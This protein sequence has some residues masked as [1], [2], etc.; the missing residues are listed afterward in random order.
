MDIKK[1]DGFELLTDGIRK[2]ELSSEKAVIAPV[3]TGKLLARNTVFNLVGQALP[4][5]VAV[6]TIPTIIRALGV[7]RFGVLTLAWMVVGY[8]SLLDL[9]L[10]RATTKFVAEFLSRGESDRCARLVWASV[11]ML[12]T[13][14]LLGAAAAAFIMPWLVNDI[15]NIP[16]ELKQESLK[17]F[18]LL[19]ISIPIVTTT[20]GMRGV[21]EA[22]QRFDLINYVKIPTY[23]AAFAAPL[24][25][26]PFS[27]NLFPIVLVLIASRLAGLLVYTWFCL[28]S[29]PALLRPRLP[30][31]NTIKRLLGYGGW[32]TVSHIIWP[33]MTYLD[34][35]I[36]GAMLTMAAVA[37]YAT[38]YELVA[39]LMII[40][41]SLTS[42]VF[43]AFSAYADRQPEKL[44]WLH[45][46]TIKYL[47][48]SLVPIVFVIIVMATPLFKIWI[49]NDFA[50]NSA[51]ILQ[52]LALAKLIN[53][54]SQVPSSAIQAMGR[55][56]ITA[57][58]HLIEL[59]I[60]LV[61][62]WIL[63]NSFGIVGAAIAWL[64]RTVLDTSLY[65][66]LFYRLSPLKPEDREKPEIKL[67]IWAVVMLLM[68][69]LFTALPGLALRIGLT[70]MVVMLTIYYCW[71]KF[72]DNDEK[73][74]LRGVLSKLI[75]IT[76]IQARFKKAIRKLFF[77]NRRQI[78]KRFKDYQVNQYLPRDILE[79]EQLERLNR[80]LNHAYKNVS[81]YH[82]ILKDSGLRENDKI[83]L[84]SLKDLEQMPFLTKEIIRSEQERIYSRDHKSRKSY[85]NSSGGTTG[86]PV[87]IIQDRDYLIAEGATFLLPKNWK[88]VDPYDSEIIIW[89]AERDTFEGKK[90]PLERVRDFLRN[91]IT[92]NSFKMIPAEI[93]NYIAI[94]NRYQPKMIRAY[95]DSIYEIAIYAR[96]K[97][98]RVRQ[99]RAIHTAACSLHDFMRME[100][101]TVFQCPVFNHYGCREVGS[102]ASECAAHDGLHILMEHNLVEIV[103]EGGNRCNP[104]QEGEIVVT[105]LDNFS[106]PIIRYRIGDVGV[107]KADAE[108]SCGCNYPKLEKVSGR[109]TDAFKTMD[110]RVISP[111][112][113]AHLLGVVH[114]GSGIRKF[115]IVQKDYR[116]VII[117]IVKDGEIHPVA[118]DDIKNK[119]GL[120]MGA[121]CQVDLNFVDDIETTKTGKFRFTVSE[122]TCVR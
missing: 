47:L 65:F 113:F 71:K 86:E 44:L 111:I 109:V 99:Q 103:D 7:G 51:I 107:M 53:S 91:R 95:A 105:N 56:D 26:L 96:K 32:L 76:S 17:A 121:D 46:R 58:L 10:G 78:L 19:A 82:E 100:I 15:L 22:T 38:P 1:L 102:I 23:I 43:P 79:R 16:S 55:P 87:K 60:Y 117:R 11:L 116:R 62:V 3:L 42:V 36:V 48:L 90:P 35:F 92:L 98:I 104:G 69:V 66:W 40:T 12:F 14:G 45:N 5:L 31:R 39:K 81:Y 63:I 110:G 119:V 67:I 88:G 61:L 64:L 73:C 50:L 122:V 97:N 37:Y 34:R 80:L 114:S 112:Y 30:S 68:A 89:G 18:Y 8:F 6:I 59:P 74:Y 94:L 13:L 84:R 49:G 85:H 20:A 115:Q 72:L 57:K 52:I 77:R 2:R 28:R 24:A 54:V 33:I 101:E 27:V 75:R 93:E 108:C 21:L 4:M 9:G 120:V 106:M 25:V 118:C 70:S 29:M 41:G 83:V